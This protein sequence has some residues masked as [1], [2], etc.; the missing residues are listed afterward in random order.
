[1]GRNE[2]AV[3]ANHEKCGDWL[4]KLEGGQ[5]VAFSMGFD[6]KYDVCSICG[7]EAPTAKDHCDH[8]MHKLGEVLSDGRVVYMRNPNP[9][10]FDISTVW[11]PADRI[12]Y[13]LR[14]VA[15]ENGVV[16]G[17]ELAEMMGIRPWGSMKQ[18]TLLRLA[19]LEKHTA[20]LGHT[21]S[22]APSKLSTEAVKSLKTACTRHG[23]DAVLQH[24]HSSGA[25]LSFE[26][27][28]DVVI[29]QS[30]LASALDVDYS[31][32]TNG[33]NYLA[34][35]DD[36]VG[37]LDGD[38]YAMIA[39]DEP[40]EHELHTA[41][42]MKLAAVQSRLLRQTIIVPAVKT[43]MA[44]DPVK[45]RG[46]ADLYLHYKLAFANHPANRDNLQT[47]QAVALSHGLQRSF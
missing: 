36:E 35:S 38:T 15:A 17:H 11:K 14:K 27:F 40:T 31:L 12:G 37:S 44:G 33:F 3:A 16:G 13:A 24:L 1:M 19:E 34:T 46:L 47:L 43:A 4:S 6:C 29:G 8:I 23:V 9:H 18:A 42:S 2:L 25:M 10:Y 20:G 30:K 5:K 26:D 39:L 45:A 22:T 41:A 21:V 7:H 32:L 28:A